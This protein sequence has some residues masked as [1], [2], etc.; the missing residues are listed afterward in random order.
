MSKL[1]AYVTFSLVFLIVFTMAMIVIFSVSGSEPSTLIT[2]VFATFG[3]E[4]L[5]C[6]LIKIFKLKEEPKK[7][8]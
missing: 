8:E 4:V 2:C 3:G 5:S 7:F 6:A 1:D